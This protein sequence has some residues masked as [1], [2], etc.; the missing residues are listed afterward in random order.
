[1]SYGNGLFGC[2]SD[3]GVCIYGLFCPFCLNANNHASIRNEQCSICHCF[4]FISEYWIRK[5]MHQKAGEAP[6]KDCG[7]CIQAN[8]CFSCAVC[9]DARGLKS[10]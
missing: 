2:F 6:D 4:N 7:D 10:G 1:M 3:C 5:Q 9:Q 8:F